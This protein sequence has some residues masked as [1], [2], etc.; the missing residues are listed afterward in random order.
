MREVRKAVTDWS[1]FAEHARFSGDEI[2]F[3]DLSHI[4]LDRSMLS[5]EKISCPDS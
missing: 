2:V 3:V 5:L 1:E 4:R